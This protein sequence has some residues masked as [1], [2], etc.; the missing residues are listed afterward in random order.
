ME[1]KLASWMAKYLS[2]GVHITLIMAA[3]AN[4]LVYFMYV[5][6]YL[7]VVI[8]IIVNWNGYSYGKSEREKNSP[9]QVVKGVQT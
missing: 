3:L 2:L 9:Y 5:S 6:K 8:K 4:L 7:M 1:H